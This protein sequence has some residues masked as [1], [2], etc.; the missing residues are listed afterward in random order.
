M[1]RLG[2]WQDYGNAAIGAWLVLSPW[3][4]GFRSER[5]ICALTWVMGALLLLDMAVAPLFLSRS[6]REWI[7]CALGISLVAWPWVL[8]SGV[9]P[10]AC[11]NASMAGLLV[12]SLSSW[13]LVAKDDGIDRRHKGR[14]RLPV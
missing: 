13:A 1:K 2:C 7:A 12:V 14:R 4:L 5:V 3:V 8:E 11:V 9:S 10:A 6:G